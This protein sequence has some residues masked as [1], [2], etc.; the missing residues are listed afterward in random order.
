MH[1]TDIGVQT[2]SDRLVGAKV[3]LAVCGG[4]G[5]VE[6]VRLAREIRRHGAEVTAFFT[7]SVENFI[8]ALSVEWACNRPVVR[9]LGPE[10]S[11]LDPYDVVL[12]APATLNTISKSAQGLADNPVTLLIASQFGRKGKLLFVP[13][14]N[15][16]LWGHPLYAEYR[17]RL[18]SWGALFLEG[19]SEEE[20]IKMP[21]PEALVGVL[22][23]LSENAN[24][25]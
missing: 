3:A 1:Q 8:T 21:D 6:T 15:S 7:P 23:N 5:A 17:K 10:V 19:A 2:K 9:T 22:I 24:R 12:V 20:R 25:R 11:H 13:T 4:I 16:V 18:E 14:M